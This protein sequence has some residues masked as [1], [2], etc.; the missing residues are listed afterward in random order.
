VSWRTVVLAKE[1]KL[2]LRMN[3][4][5][6]TNDNVVKIPLVEL[7][8]LII[9][10][11]NIVLTIHLLNALVANKTTIV[12]CDQTHNPS[13]TITA[14]YGHHRQSKNI[15][16]QISWTDERKAILWQKIIQ[17]K[18]ANQAKV[19]KALSKEGS[20]ILEE[21][22][23]EVAL[24]DATNREGHAAKVYFN[25]LFGN[26]FTR[27]EINSQNAALNYGYAVLHSLIVR[28]IVSKGY[29]TELG[30]HHINEFNQYNLASDFIEIFRPLV[31]YIVATSVTTTF[32]KEQ[33]R[34]LINVLDEK[35]YIRNGEHFLSQVVQIFIEQCIQFLNQGEEEKLLFPHLVFKKQLVLE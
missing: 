29:L 5:V 23:K 19:L 17:H 8:I 33:R 7:G 16:H 9:E 3:N 34:Q 1:A 21:F 10:N 12:I 2:S 15:M 6:V 28:T 18:I 30:I 24:D 20:G 4:L 35:V 13:A 11:P 14:I 27:D 22:V 31:D 25:R 32:E 26:E